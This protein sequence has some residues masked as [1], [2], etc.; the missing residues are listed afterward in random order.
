MDRFAEI[1]AKGMG[2]RAH[3]LEEAKPLEHEKRICI[4]ED[5]D[6]KVLQTGDENHSIE[7]GTEPPC[8][9]EALYRKLKEIREKMSVYLA[10]YA[11]PLHPLT[12]E[13]PIESFL[14]DGESK[15]VLPHYGGPVGRHKAVYE[16]EFFVEVQ[17]GK[18]YDICF[19]GA[20]YYAVVYINDFCM[21]THEGFFAPF[22]FPVTDALIKGVNRLKIELYNDYVY[23]GNGSGGVSAEGDKLYA[24]TGLGWDDPMLGW[25]HCPAGMGIYGPVCLKE[26]NE[27]HITDLFVRPLL[28]EQAAELW[29]EIDNAGYRS[30]EGRIRYSIFGQ[31]FHETVCKDIVY[32]PKTCET[33][34]LGDTFTQAKRKDSIGKGMPMPIRHG[35]NIYRIKVKMPAPKLWEPDT[36]YLY[37]AQAAVLVGDQA[38]D[39]RKCQFGMRSFIQDLQGARKGM[40]YLNGRKIRLRGANTMGFEQQDVMREDWGQLVDD[41]LLAKLCNMN[42]LRFTQRPVQEEVYDYCDRLGLM[43]QTDLP[44]FGCMRRTKVSEGIRQAEEMICMVRK[45]PCNILITYINEP[46]PNAMNEP[47]RH[48]SREEL[49]QFFRMCD[50]AVRLLNPDQVIKHV[51]GDYDPPT[52]GMPDNHCYTLWYNGHGMDAGRLH[53]GYWLPVRPGWYY[54]CGE[55]GAEGLEDCEVMEACYPREWLQEPFDPGKIVGAQTGDFHRFFY[56]TQ[57]TMKDWVRES[58][59]HQRFATKF[60]TEAFRRDDRMVSNAIHLFIDAW[61]SG[62][63][64]AIMDSKRNPKPAYFA[65]RDALRPILLS[66]RTDRFRYFAGE[67]IRVECFLCNDTNKEDPH[68]RIVYELYRKG[69]LAARGTME[70]QLQDCQAGYTSECSFAVENVTKRETVTLRAVLLDGQGEALSAQMLEID[71]FEDK[72]VPANQDVVLL[73][74]K[75]GIHEIAG[76]QIEVK[77]CGMLPVHFVSRKTGHR[78]VA[79]FGPRDFS[80]WYDKEKDR[81]AP[82]AERTFTAPGFTPI[83]LSGNK[84]AKGQWESA[85]V[86]AEKW[87]RNKRYIVCTADLRLEEPIAKLFLAELMKPEKK[88]R[89]K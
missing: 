13:Y 31:N 78:C 8:T 33:V 45:H 82:I 51:D 76:E 44:L 79:K 55:Y 6:G 28:E 19:G 47:H 48:L 88:K 58:Q 65:Y 10:D 56:D 66:L 24:A 14:L 64:K 73:C 83:L 25:H 16:A 49:E 81:I 60:M 36:P 74:P 70:A 9:K 84:G 5:A 71:I 20:D 75:I 4:L 85:Y 3:L 29:V 50:M 17:Q 54:G 23:Q 52:E 15:V 21:G 40:F 38:L 41:I 32:L 67:E 87:Y 11:P 72:E 46:F 42:F 35:K 12:R 37:Q 69:R 39:V 53:K 26:R 43:T 89:E 18:A 2:G 59:E 86:C 80:F 22:S 34:G 7:I 68:C 61:P 62:W 63:M 27:I 1:A 77:E 57:D 30:V